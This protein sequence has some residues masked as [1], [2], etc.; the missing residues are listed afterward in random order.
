[1]FKV[2]V[3]GAAVRGPAEAPVTIVEFTDYQCPY[4]ARANATVTRL[5][6]EY[7]PK[8]RLAVRQ[9]PLEMH[10]NA[11]QAALAALAAGE[12]GQY[13]AMHDKLFANP[14]TLD[15]QSL[16]RFAQELGLSLPTFRASLDSPKLHQA[17]QK[18]LALA[19]SLG[20]NGTPTF[21]IN[22]RRLVGAQPVEAFKQVIDEELARAD[23]L[24]QQGVR[25]EQLYESLT[26][27]GMTTGAAKGAPADGCKEGCA[28]GEPGEHAVGTE[29]QA[30]DVPAGAP[31]RGPDTARVTVVVWSDFQC[32]FCARGAQTLRQLQEQYGK[33]VRL[34][35]RND[36]L[37]F[38]RDAP[39]AAAAALAAQEQGRF[40]E[41]HD[42]LFAHQ[43]ALDRASLE[44][45]AQDL[46]LDLVRFRQAL[47][48]KK[49]EASL[50]GDTEAANRAGVSGTPTFFV[51]GHRVMGAQPL[52]TFKALVDSELAKAR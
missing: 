7:G 17:L 26:A 38:H 2:P 24:V 16:E 45:Y 10:P 43:G 8:L 21:F 34:V 11:R 1:V 3:E 25:P 30:I 29:V 15:A 42:A 6:E 48:S 32:P 49:F 41:Y 20:L 28:G 18:D 33:D 44:R 27:Q 4:C 51:N 22:G 14:R 12:Q 5:L 39:L 46:G 9:N 19:G 40:W 31:S 52:D 36:P 47:D 37:P 35:F 23:Q 13:W 50:A